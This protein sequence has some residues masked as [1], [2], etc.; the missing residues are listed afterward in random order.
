MWVTVTDVLNRWVDQ[1]ER[2]AEADVLLTT[3]VEDAQVIIG[4]KFSNIQSRIDALTLNPTLVKIVVAQMVQRAYNT[5]LSGKVSYSY[6][7]GPF[8]EQGSYSDSSK[9]GIYLTEDEIQLLQPKEAQSK[10]FSINMDQ[11]QANFPINGYLDNPYYYNFPRS[12]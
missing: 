3:L 11:G 6:S 4:N 2:P 7:S 8:S 9:K 12:R 5:E 1:E 10:A